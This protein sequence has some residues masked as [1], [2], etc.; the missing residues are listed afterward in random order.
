[1]GKIDSRTGE[2]ATLIWWGEIDYLEGGEAH[3]ST[4]TVLVACKVAGEILRSR[5]QRGKRDAQLCFLCTGRSLTLALSVWTNSSWLFSGR[6]TKD[7][8]RLYS[9]RKQ[10]GPKRTVHHSVFFPPG[11]FPRGSTSCLFSCE[12]QL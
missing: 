2:G 9:H 1:M 12:T 8:L 3:K 11:N 6:Y 10:R 5:S 7:T 4:C